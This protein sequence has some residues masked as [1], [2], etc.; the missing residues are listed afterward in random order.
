MQRTEPVKV[1]C[2]SSSLVSLWFRLDTHVFLFPQEASLQSVEKNWDKGVVGETPEMCNTQLYLLLTSIHKHL[3][4]YCTQ[5]EF[6]QSTVSRVFYRFKALILCTVQHRESI[7]LYGDLYG[8]I[9]IIHFT[10]PQNLYNHSCPK[11][12]IRY[13]F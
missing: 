4:A 1:C 10:K 12:H 11:H 8:S 2:L 7:L 5:P 6:T 3:F 13:P 9:G